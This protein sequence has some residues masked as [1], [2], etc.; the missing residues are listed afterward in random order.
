M[1]RKIMMNIK[2][3]IEMIGLRQAIIQEGVKKKLLN[4]NKFY[5]IKSK[6]IQILK[7]KLVIYKKWIQNNRFYMR[8]IIN[9]HKNKVIKF[10][11]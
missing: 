10:L 7:R 4:N 3:K 5:N 6:I 1:K 9:F 11:S 8:K 2:N